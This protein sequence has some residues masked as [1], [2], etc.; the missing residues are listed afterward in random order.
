LSSCGKADIIIRTDLDT[1]LPS[2]LS[3]TTSATFA[4]AAT[5]EN[6]KMLIIVNVSS[7]TFHLSDTCR[8]VMAMSEKNKQIFAVTD[9]DELISLGYKPCST[10]FEHYK[11]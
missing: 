5:D 11:E 2:A 7:K 10:C 1:T 9:I 8:H 3:A 4:T 6:G